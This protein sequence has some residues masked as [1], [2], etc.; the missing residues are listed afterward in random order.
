MH[1]RHLRDLE[2]FT[3]AKSFKRSDAESH[4]LPSEGKRMKSRIASR[5]IAFCGYCEPL[6]RVIGIVHGIEIEEIIHSHSD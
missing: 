2:L 5:C 6:A 4:R 3:P 1:T